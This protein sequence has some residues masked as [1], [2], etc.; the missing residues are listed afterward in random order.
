YTDRCGTPNGR[1]LTVTVSRRRVFTQSERARRMPASPIR[2]L[3][4]LADAAKARGTRVY[5]LTI[6][7]PD[8]ETPACMRDRL[9]QMDA[10]FL[11]YSPSGGTPAYLRSLQKYYE[12]RLG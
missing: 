4:P 1:G 5:H 7:Q 8:I 6:G 2:K 3:V 9:K 11:E 10:R 12:R